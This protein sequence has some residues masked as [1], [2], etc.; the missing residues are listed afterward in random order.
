MLYDSKYLIINTSFEKKAQYIAKTL[1][2]YRN[3]NVFASPCK[4]RVIRLVIL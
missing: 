4:A 2:L 1:K 3:W